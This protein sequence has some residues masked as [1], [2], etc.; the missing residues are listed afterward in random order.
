MPIEPSLASVL[1]RTTIAALMLL[2]PMSAAW[3]HHSIAGQFDMT[4]TL[5]LNGVVATLEWTNPHVYL[6]LDTKDTQG[7]S[8]VWKLETLPV[9]MM[10]KAGIKKQMLITGE[11][12]E[13]DICPA[14]NG[15]DHLGFIL[16][17]KFPDGRRFQF[18]K[19]PNGGAIAVP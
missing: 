11:L 15:T 7:R 5:R 4:K 14:R 17:I 18:S 8:V 6:F 13:M 10:R 16:N 2:A 19:D 3:T 1:S 12:V 9:A